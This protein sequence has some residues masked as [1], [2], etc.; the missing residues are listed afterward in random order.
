MSGVAKIARQIHSKTL[1]YIVTI[2]AS[3]S[4]CAAEANVSQLIQNVLCGIALPVRSMSIK[5]KR[6]IGT[7]IALHNRCVLLVNIFQT[8][9]ITTKLLASVLC[10]QLGPSNQAS[11]CTGS[12][13]VV[14]P[15]FVKMM[16]L[17]QWGQQH[18]RT[19]NVNQ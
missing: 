9:Q 8:I 5:V 6:T 15:P 17:K 12:Q 19:A 10:A 18:H 3:F 14:L 1:P 2:R 13:R 7:P 4:E 11:C 16:N